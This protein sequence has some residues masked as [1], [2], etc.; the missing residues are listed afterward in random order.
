MNPFRKVHI[1]VNVYSDGKTKIPRG[2]IVY[3]ERWGSGG[4]VGS[5]KV[6]VVKRAWSFY[7]VRS[8]S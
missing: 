2:K 4:N 3:T 5:L 1:W 6:C 8:G 7:P